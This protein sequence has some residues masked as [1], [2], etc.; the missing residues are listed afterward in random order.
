[1]PF[2]PEHPGRPRIFTWS[3]IFE[4]KDFNSI[5][6][7]LRGFSSVSDF[8]EIVPPESLRGIELDDDKVERFLNVMFDLVQI[9]KQKKDVE[10]GE[11]AEMLQEYL[12]SLPEE[13]REKILS[14]IREYI[15]GNPR[16]P[17]GEEF[18]RYL[19]VQD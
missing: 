6:R 5:R 16:L 11:V 8:T 18:L 3:E 14:R 4:S 13:E 17:R 12:Q 1:M 10:P 15:R 19:E 9:S 7:T 2:N